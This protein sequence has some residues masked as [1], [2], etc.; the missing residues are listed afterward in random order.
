MISKEANSE[1]L[2][3]KVLRN[4][5]ELIRLYYKSGKYPF[6]F[7]PG[8][9]TNGAS[10]G[11]MHMHFWTKISYIKNILLCQWT[12]KFIPLFQNINS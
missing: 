1:H 2:R 4:G 11:M 6:F 7:Y 12:I 9:C 3:N 5:A 8:M 10:Q